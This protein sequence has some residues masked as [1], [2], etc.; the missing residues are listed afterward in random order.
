MLRRLGSH[1]IRLCYF[2]LLFRVLI[3]ANWQDL[4]ELIATM[5]TTVKQANKSYEQVLKTADSSWGPTATKTRLL[6]E[7]EDLQNL[8]SVS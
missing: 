3:Q 8:M 5:D 7:M 4:Q 6:N 1:E 2:L